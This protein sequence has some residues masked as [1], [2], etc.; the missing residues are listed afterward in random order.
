MTADRGMDELRSA[1]VAEARRWI[2]TPYRHGASAPGA[3]ADCLGLIR[4]VWRALYGA[5]PAETPPY[6][7]DWGDAAGAEALLAAA[8]ALM[9][10]IDPA[11]AAPGDVLLFRMRAGWPAKH[12]GLRAAAPEGAPTV[13]HAYSGR[14]VLESA[15]G[16]ALSRRIAAA[17]RFPS[18]RG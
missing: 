5:E 4:G 10:E 14:A 7:A 1:A 6:T 9:V 16:P 8:R 2:G 3:G 11:E 15:L 18:G 17:F 12:L 13:I